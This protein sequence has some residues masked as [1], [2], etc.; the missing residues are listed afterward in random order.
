LGLGSGKRWS[1]DWGPRRGSDM[2]GSESGAHR[3]SR[4]GEDLGGIDIRPVSMGAS[5]LGQDVMHIY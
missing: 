5:I 3:R 2:R 4:W 1:Q